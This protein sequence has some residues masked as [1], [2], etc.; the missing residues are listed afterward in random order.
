MCVCV[1]VCVCVYVCL[2]VCVCEVKTSNI[3]G[4]GKLTS[5]KIISCLGCVSS[6]YLLRSKVDSIR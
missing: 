2:C 5:F 3:Q 1:C 4:I 6:F